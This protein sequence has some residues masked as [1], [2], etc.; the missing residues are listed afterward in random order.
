[1]PDGQGRLQRLR[2]SLLLRIDYIGKRP[3]VRARCIIRRRLP[4]MLPTL[5]MGRKVR[6]LQRALTSR[7]LCT[8]LTH[9]LEG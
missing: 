6:T 2:P 8:S 1:V 4:L 7:D 9:P 3:E 5:K